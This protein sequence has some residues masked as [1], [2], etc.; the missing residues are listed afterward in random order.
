MSVFSQEAITHNKQIQV[1]HRHCLQPLFWLPKPSYV[2]DLTHKYRDHVPFQL[3]V[4]CVIYTGRYP[5]S[6]DDKIISAVIS[7]SVANNVR[8]T[9]HAFHSSFEYM[10]G[11]LAFEITE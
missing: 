2:V 9:R 6:L 5:L 4:R 1:S 8:S 10:E 7:S 11:L 3:I